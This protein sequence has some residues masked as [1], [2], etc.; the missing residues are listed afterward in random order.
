MESFKPTTTIQLNDDAAAAAAS[1]RTTM[2]PPPPPPLTPSELEVAVKELHLT[3]CT[4]GG[5]NFPRVNRKFCDPLKHGEPKFALF[6]F[7]KSKDAVADRDGF[8]GV[9]KI[10]GAFYCQEDADKKAEEL[11]RDVDST[12]SIYTCVMGTPFPLVAQGYAEDVAEIDLQNKVETAIAENVR[13]KRNQ[14]KKEMQELSARK[15]ALMKDIDPNTKEDPEEKY[16]EQRVKLAHLKYAIDEHGRK[17]VECKELKDKCVA[18]LKEQCIENPDFEKNYLERYR[19]GRRAA[20]I[21]EETDLT[22]FMK[23]MSDELDN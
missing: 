14:E 12:N 7:V 1:S 19:R 22:G 3:T 6:S 16:V 13:E 4:T 18:F 20:N 17:L 15:E 9:A 5:C 8:F 23:F 2:P 21:P 11:I 10:R